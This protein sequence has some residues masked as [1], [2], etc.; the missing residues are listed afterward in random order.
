M[1]DKGLPVLQ[2]FLKAGGTVQLLNAAGAAVGTV[3][4]DGTVTLNAGATLADLKSVKVTA[5]D[6]TTRTYAF[7]RDPGKPG[8]VK[9]EFPL[10]SG[11]VVSLPLAAVVN[12]QAEAHNQNSQAQPK[13]SKAETPDTDDEADG[14]D[15]GGKPTENPGNKP[16]KPTTPPQRPQ[17]VTR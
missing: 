9:I 10:T 6:K 15:K 7:T 16:D 8:A 12:R 2:E 3:N 1:T 13:D 11:K 14:D 17:K 5:A 4:P